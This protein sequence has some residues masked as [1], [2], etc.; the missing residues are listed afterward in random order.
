M[1][2]HIETLQQLSSKTERLIIGLM[3]GTSLD[4]LDVALCKIHGDGLQ[5]K[6]ELLE[7]TTVEY[8]DTYRRLIRDIFSKRDVDLQQVCL[9]NPWIGTLHGEMILEC[10]KNWQCQPE[11]IDLIASHGQTIF[12]APQSLHGVADMPNA[13]LQIGDGDHLAVK[14]GIITISDFRQ[15]HI[16][17][18]GEGAPL[19]VYGDFLVFADRTEN[20]VML[21]M[22]GIANFTFL[23]ASLD[24][25]A[26][27]STDVG[28]GNTLMDAYVQKY[29]AP[30]T[31]DADAAI[32]RAGQVNQALLSALK[33]H[34]FFVQG[35]PKTTGPELFNLDYL[36]RA[37]TAS[38][39]QQLSHED[40]MATLNRFSADMIVDALN[41]CAGA[42]GEYHL[43]GS[44]GGVHNP[45][46]MDNIRSQLP[47]VSVHS[48][49]D[50][51][52]NPDAKEAVLFALLANECVAGG[53]AQF[54]N[55]REG[56]PSVTM[57]K[58]SFPD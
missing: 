45:L 57:G 56:I 38:Q 12:H 8:D 9:L 58:I 52:I 7:F 53:K 21:N 20:R 40:V 43:Y 42:L 25:Q 17:A 54:G 14:T 24:A 41:R 23:P 26:V 47:Q 6:V 5:S 36:A 55:A 51:G 35:F 46:L 39:T 33:A 49:N 37:Q 19:A 22:G 48:T 28:T 4:G 31:Y 15:K 32:A 11:D 3:S 2:R 44:G 18:G 34:D 27:F 50:L 1:H 10:L 13:T 29:F 30:K 16:A